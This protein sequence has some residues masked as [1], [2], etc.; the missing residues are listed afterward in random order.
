MSVSGR[1]GKDQAPISWKESSERCRRKSG[2][3]WGGL[4]IGVGEV[5]RSL[6]PRR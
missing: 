1:E 5:L 3:G 6:L 4:Y 2:E